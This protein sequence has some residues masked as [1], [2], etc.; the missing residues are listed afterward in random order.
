MIITNTYI[1]YRCIV[2]NYMS[3]LTL[4]LLLTRVDTYKL[5]DFHNFYNVWIYNISKV[6]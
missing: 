1:I 5:Y 3:S 6:F 4:D 2:L